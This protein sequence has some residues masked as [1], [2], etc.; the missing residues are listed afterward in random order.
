MYARKKR[1]V[2]LAPSLNSFKSRLNKFWNGHACTEINHD[3]LHSW[4]SNINDD[5]ISKRA[6]GSG[7]AT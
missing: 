1:P 6:F 2:V 5:T 3:L 7:L 4:R